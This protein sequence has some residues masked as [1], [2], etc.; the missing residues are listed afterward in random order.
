MKK[1][2]N[3]AVHAGGNTTTTFVTKSPE[4]TTSASNIKDTTGTS[5]P[6]STTTSITVRYN[7]SIM[8]TTEWFRTNS[9]FTIYRGFSPYANFITAVLQKIP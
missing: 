3:F 2:N 4:K 8:V 9:N 7:G 6:L 1:K 5:A